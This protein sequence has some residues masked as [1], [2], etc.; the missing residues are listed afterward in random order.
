MSDTVVSSGVTS[1]GLYVSHLDTL[2]VLSG[3]HVSHI[4]IRG[5]ETIS[6]GGTAI[7]DVVD[8]SL[9]SSS[10][11]ALPS[12]VQFVFGVASSTVVHAGGYQVV[13]GGGVADNTRVDANGF[14]CVTAEGHT[15]NG[16]ISEL[17]TLDVAKGGEATGVHLHGG[18]LELSSLGAY[19]GD[20][21]GGGFATGTVDDGAGQIDVKTSGIASGSIVDSGGLVTVY[22]GGEVVDTYLRGH[23]VIEVLSGESISARISAGA[24]ETLFAGESINDVVY[25]GGLVTVANSATVSALVVSSGGAF[26]WFTSHALVSD[27]TLRP[28]ADIFVQ[29]TSASAT[30]SGGKL[31]VFNSGGVEVL[32]AKLQHGGSGLV[33]TATPTSAGSTEI[34]VSKESGAERHL[35][36]GLHFAQA[37]AQVTQRDAAVPILF[38][39]HRSVTPMVI[40]PP[41]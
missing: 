30:I 23:A 15:S 19:P 38:H 6:A 26:Q 34:V 21:V 27:L 20:T 18:L 7:G 24:A 11:D 41:H 4:G 39:A 13:S 3:G 16:I 25:S 17:G 33:V 9:V 5:V 28:G 37:I 2:E 14:E 40:A 22:A 35:A 10:R 1:T 12:G 29:Y 31:E 32:S 36:P 8:A